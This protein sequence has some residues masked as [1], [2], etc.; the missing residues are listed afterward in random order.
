M[1]HNEIMLKLQ[2]IIA[3]VLDQDDIVL[4]ETTSAKDIDGWDSLAHISIIAAVQ[5]EFS[6]SFSMDEIISM[7]CVADIVNAIIKKIEC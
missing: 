4:S 1:T 3:D 2:N 5:E 6:V 7:R